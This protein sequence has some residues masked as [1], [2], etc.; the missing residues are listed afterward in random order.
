MKRIDI[1][2]LGGVAV[3]LAVVQG[4]GHFGNGQQQIAVTTD[5]DVG[6][7]RYRDFISVCKLNCSPP[8]H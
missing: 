5:S 6:Q 2:G 1:L 4:N 3:D 7:R 8:P